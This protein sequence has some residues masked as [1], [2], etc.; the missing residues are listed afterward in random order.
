[1][2]LQGLTSF[3]SSSVYGVGSTVWSWPKMMEAKELVVTTRLSEA[4]LRHD[5]YTFSV[6]S[7]A[8]LTSSS[9]TQS[10]RKNGLR[11]MM[12]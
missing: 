5:A 7:T 10:R 9:A 12:R 1:M 11:T 3:H 8:G 6:P 4:D 2:Y